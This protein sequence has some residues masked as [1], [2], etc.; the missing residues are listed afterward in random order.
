MT[1]GN[2]YHLSS[3]CSSAGKDAQLNTPRANAQYDATFAQE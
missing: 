2:F 3:N 1:E